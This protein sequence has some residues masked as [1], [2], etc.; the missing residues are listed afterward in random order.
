MSQAGLHVHTDEIFAASDSSLW[1]WQI[2]VIFTELLSRAIWPAIS[3]G[4]EWRDEDNCSIIHS[5][6]VWGRHG[7]RHILR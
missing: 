5:S 4:D 6:R 1:Q 2:A 3:Y 7:K